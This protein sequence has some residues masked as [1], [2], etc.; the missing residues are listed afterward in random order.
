ME[1]AAEAI[2]AAADRYEGA[3]PVNLGSGEEIS[4]KTLAEIIRTLTAFP[5]DIVWDPSQPN[6]QPRRKLDWYLA[7]RGA[8]SGSHA[9]LDP[10]GLERGSA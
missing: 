6:G 3:D 7:S 9:A 8:Q 2:I 4:M 1:D 10:H 5:G